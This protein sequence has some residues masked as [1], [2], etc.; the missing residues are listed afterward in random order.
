VFAL[1]P[2]VHGC[3]GST[4]AEPALDDTGAPEPRTH[5]GD[6]IRGFAAWIRAQWKWFLATTVLALGLFQIG[7]TVPAWKEIKAE[8]QQR[9][10]NPEDLA[11]EQGGIMSNLRL[12][13]YTVE[14]QYYLEYARLLWTG[15]ADLDYIFQKRFAT[16]PALPSGRLWPYRDVSVEYPPLAMLVVATPWLVSGDDTWTYR[17]VLGAILLVLWLGCLYLGVKTA[18]TLGWVPS[19]A[20][21]GR[22]GRRLA[23]A[24]CLGALFLGRLRRPRSA[25]RLM[26]NRRRAGE[27]RYWL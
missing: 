7:F 11:R 27:P 14:D 4:V 21:D 19:F 12:Y 15:N 23:M 16:R 10:I 26:T 1:C 8:A 5:D 13:F 18:A 24:A 6:G 20:P 17:F 2:P 3:Y 25:L 9:G 22:T